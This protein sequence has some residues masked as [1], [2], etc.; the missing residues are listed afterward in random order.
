MDLNKIFQSNTFRGAILGIGAVII[1]LLVF[2]TGMIIG[3]KKADFSCR[4]SDNYHRNFG[5]PRGGFMPG[6]GDRDF[7]ES[8]GTFGQII[9]IDGTNLVI[10]GRNDVEKVVIVDNNTVINRFNDTVKLTELKIDDDIVVIGEPNQQ[11]QIVAKLIR[12]M[13]KPQA[14]QDAAPLGMPSS[15]PVQ[16]ENNANPGN[17]VPSVNK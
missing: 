3:T 10:K 1:L 7:I 6:L 13:P 12:I 11:G 8:N 15:L 2:K 5:G 4:W 9:K 17:F 16:P 14:G